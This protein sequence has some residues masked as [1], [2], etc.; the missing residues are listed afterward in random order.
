MDGISLVKEAMNPVFL[1]GVAGMV[2]RQSI[3][4]ERRFTELEKDTNEAKAKI[5]SLWEK[6]GEQEDKI[7][8]V[9]EKVGELRGHQE[10]R[11]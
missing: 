8:D 1:L 3:T 11:N 5:S 9:R 6:Y 7:A 10:G 4:M 2:W